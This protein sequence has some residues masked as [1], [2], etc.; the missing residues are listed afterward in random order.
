MC[1]RSIQY[2]IGQVHASHSSTACL[3]LALSTAHVSSGSHSICRTSRFWVAAGAEAK[4][5]QLFAQQQTNRPKGH[6]RQLVD[7]R[8]ERS[9][10][11]L[12]LN[13]WQPAHTG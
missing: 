1:R 5:H 9:E 6:L 10:A 3:V 8:L 7:A 13:S 12:V 4:L 2:V 11:C